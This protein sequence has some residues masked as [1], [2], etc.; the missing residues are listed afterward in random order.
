MSLNTKRVLIADEN[1]G[2]R[3]AFKWH[4]EFF[5]PT[6]LVDTASTYAETENKIKSTDYD[7]IFLDNQY[8]DSPNSGT[9]L[10]K[11][12]S[13][14]YK[15]NSKIILVTADHDL[16]VLQS[17]IASGAFYYIHKSGN[18][19]RKAIELILGMET[20]A[21]KPINGR[22]NVIYGQIGRAHV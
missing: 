6:Y 1:K 9:D 7:L 11:T 13:D 22:V 19:Q 20:G 5:R 4:V 15:K 18:T 8:P 12:L 14:D 3:T 16:E 17:A 21:P 2:F 10:L